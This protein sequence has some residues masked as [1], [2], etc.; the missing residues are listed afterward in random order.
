MRRRVSERSYPKSHPCK[1]GIGAQLDSCLRTPVAPNRNLTIDSLTAYFLTMSAGAIP[2]RVA[3]T[4]K[5]RGNRKCCST[6]IRQLDEIGDSRSKESGP[7][8]NCGPCSDSRTFRGVCY[9]RATP[10]QQ[11][12][13]VVSAA[14]LSLSSE[15]GRGR[16]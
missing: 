8:S 2:L 5:G 16:G 11:P 7:S 9:M 15:I 14:W 13:H 4:S 3:R 10:I 1:S 6:L 12:Y